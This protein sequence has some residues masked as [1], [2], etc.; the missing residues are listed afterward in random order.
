LPIQRTVNRLSAYFVP[1]VMAVSGATFFRWMAA[2]AGFGTALT[3]AITV[4]LV[5]C[6]CAL[7]LATPAAVMVGT[8]QA[9]RHLHP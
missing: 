5:A 6:P 7:E 8:G 1:A 3:H 2:G 9:A 4:L